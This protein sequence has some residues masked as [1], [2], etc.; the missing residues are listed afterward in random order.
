VVAARKRRGIQAVR[1][2]PNP[3]RDERHDMPVQ[4]E[5]FDE[6]DILFYAVRIEAACN[7]PIGFIAFLPTPCVLPLYGSRIPLACCVRYIIETL[8]HHVSSAR[9]S[10][11][12]QT[13][14]R[15]GESCCDSNSCHSN[16]VAEGEKFGGGPRGMPTGLFKFVGVKLN[17]E[18]LSGE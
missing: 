4:T 6:E 18:D 11:S 7:R 1:R 9:F 17:V 3:N 15:H 16:M 13:R 10:P 12:C 2:D 14:F 8:V 5:P